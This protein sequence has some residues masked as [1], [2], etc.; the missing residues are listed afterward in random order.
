MTQSFAITCVQRKP[1]ERLETAIRWAL[2]RYLFA[3]LP[4]MSYLGN[5]LTVVYPIH[6]ICEDQLFRI[7]GFRNV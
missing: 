1:V 5:L 3:H 6:G 4:D 2:A 7:A